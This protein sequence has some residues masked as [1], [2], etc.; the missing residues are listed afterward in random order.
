MLRGFI[1]ALAVTTI[2]AAL[3]SVG[4]WVWGLASA[5]VGFLCCVWVDQSRLRE[6]TRFAAQPDVEVTPQSD[7]VVQ[8]FFTRERALRETALEAVA[9][10]ESVQVAVR[11]LPDAVIVLD[12]AQRVVWC[13][14]AAQ[15]LL[16]VENDIERRRAFSESVRDHEVLS[17][18]QNPEDSSVTLTSPVN[19]ERML[20]LSTTRCDRDTRVLVARDVTELKR[21]EAVRRDFIANLSHELKTPLTVIAGFSETLLADEAIPAAQKRRGLEHIKAQSDNMRRLVQDLLMLS[22]LESAL[23]QAEKNALVLTTL[24]IRCVEQ[25][26]ALARGTQKIVV[27]TASE[28]IILLGQEEEIE[29]ALNN[30]LTNALKYS[31]DDGAVEVAIDIDA[32]RQLWLR[33]KDNGQGIA[34]EHLPRLTERFYRVDR[35]RSRAAGGTGLGLAIVKHI[36]NRHDGSLEIV[37]T[38]GVGSQFSLR[39]PPERVRSAQPVSTTS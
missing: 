25:V 3:G 5:A 21:V 2:A 20:A 24:V 1:P 12:A 27:R 15:A 14:T 19:G 34:P 36:M 29:S 23:T 33:V 4:G 9:Q 11:G 30:L 22:R 32:S 26:N 28:P 7:E 37:S 18:L 8:Q 38:L 6:L 10:R 31:P 35:G 39:F 16:G 17:F 13:N